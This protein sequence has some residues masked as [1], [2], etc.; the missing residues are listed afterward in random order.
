MGSAIGLMLQHFVTFVAGFVLAFYY[1]WRLS[2]ALM[3]VVPLFVVVGIISAYFEKQGTAGGASHGV[4][5][6][7]DDKK[8]DPTELA[9]LFSNEVLISIRS[10]KAIPILLASK[11]KEYEQ[12]LEDIVPYVKKR[13]L[14]IGLSLGGMFFAFL[15]AMYS[16]GYWYGGKLVDNG[17]IEIGDMYLCMFALPIGAMS[18]GQLGTANAD[19]V[20]ARNAANKFFSLKD[21]KPNIKAPE[22]KKE[23]RSERLKGDITFNKVSF[24]YPTA[25]D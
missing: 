8:A 7:N 18:L 19:I 10:V 15:G 4:G 14:G 16:I 20:K 21:R 6:D 1:S 5:D 23:S 22:N 11:L 24:R 13:S 2:L 25:P 3:A 9:G 17:T 12:K